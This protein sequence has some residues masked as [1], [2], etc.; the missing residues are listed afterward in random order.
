M[1]KVLRKLYF[2]LFKPKELW[3]MRH[4]DPK[5]LKLTPIHANSYS[6]YKVKL[7]NCN[8]HNEFLTPDL[9]TLLNFKKKETLSI[10][11]TGPSIRTL[12]FKGLTNTDFALVNGGILLFEKLQTLN[13]T[14]YFLVTDPNYIST[15]FKEIKEKINEN[16]VCLFSIRS[17]YEIS[18]ID[19][20][21]LL[22]RKD[23][24]FIINQLSEPYNEPKLS[25]QNLKQSD[26]EQNYYINEESYSAFSKNIEQG[27]FNGGTVVFSM[28][29]IAAYLK[30]QHIDIYGMDLTNAKRFYHEKKPAKSRL[31]IEYQSLILPHLK[32]ASDVCKKLNIQVLNR[33]K[34]SALPSS[35]FSKDD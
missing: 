3:H 25:I 26:T 28:L 12:N 7:N 14:T 18:T 29:Q 8:S 4:Y 5:I 13:Q 9:K 22:S 17:Y 30:Y 33:S 19:P 24:I 31:E 16:I 21:F 34:E 10:L 15:H 2:K 6:S 35:V 32:L 23:K 11:A 27:I 1:R 20:E